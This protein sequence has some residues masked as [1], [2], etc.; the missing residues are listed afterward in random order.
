MKSTKFDN[1]IYILNDGI[2]V[3]ALGIRFNLICLI[4]DNSYFNN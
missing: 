4:R 1:K 2:D 3:L